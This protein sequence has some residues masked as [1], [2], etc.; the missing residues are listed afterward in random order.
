MRI[1]LTRSQQRQLAP[2]LD[3]ALAAAE[4]QEP[5]MTIAQLYIVGGE[6]VCFFVT[7]ENAHKIQKAIGAVPV[8]TL[9]SRVDDRL[10]DIGTEKAPTARK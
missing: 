1:K 7:Q 6:M 2:L 5:G 10:L 3:Q 9:T 4:I 8:G